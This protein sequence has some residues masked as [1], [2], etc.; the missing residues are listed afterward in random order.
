MEAKT[1]ASYKSIFQDSIALK[2][3]EQ[4]ILEEKAG[5]EGLLSPVNQMKEPLDG[6]GEPC[7]VSQQFKL[8]G[9]SV[10]F[11]PFPSPKRTFKSDIP[12]D[13]LQ[14]SKLGENCPESRESTGASTDKD[15]VPNSS[16]EQLTPRNLAEL[17]FSNLGYSN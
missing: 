2:D 14:D 17:D 5:Q 15:G 3:N 1:Q 16:V 8:S 7:L 6:F 4:L 12:L 11:D 9:Q 10:A 13:V